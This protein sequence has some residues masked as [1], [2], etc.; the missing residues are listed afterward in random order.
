MKNKRFFW[1]LLLVW[2]PWL[3]TLIGL[4]NAF[5]GIST[6]KATGLAAVAGGLTEMFV[7][8]G[9]ITT[10]VFQVVAIVLLL[11][12]FEAGHQLRNLFSV[13]SVF[14]SVLMLLL[15]CSFVWLTWTR[16][17]HG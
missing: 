11:R 17:A 14:F 16:A 10:L 13:I 9:L 5:R 7:L 15:V 3:P 2:A 4:A 1:G 12:A 8:V 6:E